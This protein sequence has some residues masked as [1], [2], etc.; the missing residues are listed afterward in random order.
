MLNFLTNLRDMKSSLSSGMVLLF[1]LWLVFGNEVAD[2]ES[3]DS[4]A[5]NLRRLAE[6]L[7]RLGRWDCSHSW[8]IFSASYYPLIASYCLS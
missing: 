4:L 6:Y 2:V 7:A 8:P 5:G 1:C 3:D